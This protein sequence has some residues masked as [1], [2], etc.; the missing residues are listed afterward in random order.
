VVI[1]G[2]PSLWTDVPSG[3]PQ[4]SVLGPTLFTILINDLDDDIKS[5]MLKFADDVKLIGRADSAEDEPRYYV[6][7]L[8]ILY[9]SC[10]T[11]TNFTKSLIISKCVGSFIYNR[12]KIT[13][14]ILIIRV[15][16]MDH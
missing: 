15:C 14:V 11:S 5:D 3:V 8:D 10:N 7:Y 13:W 1:N 9:V 12:P 6:A 2:Q 4:G 16:V